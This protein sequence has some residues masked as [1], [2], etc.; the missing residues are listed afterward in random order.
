MGY[1]PPVRDDQSFEYGKRISPARKGIKPTSSVVKGKFH[2]VLTE[3]H[4]NYGKSKSQKN[5]DGKKEIHKIVCSVT[6]KG[7]YIDEVI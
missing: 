7:K 4:K 5:K 2:Q 6:G 1:I 3:T